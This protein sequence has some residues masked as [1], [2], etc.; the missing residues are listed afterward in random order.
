MVKQSSI[1][2]A[3]TLD[4]VSQLTGL[5][6]RQLAY[7]D[8]IGFY[9]PSLAQENRRVANSRV[10]TF[11]DLLA[12]QVLNTLRKDHRVSLQHLRAVKDRLCMLSDDEWK[13]RRLFVLNKKVVFDDAEGARREIVSGQYV[14]DIPLGVVRKN[15]ED[16]VEQIGR[17]TQAQIA[18]S[19]HRRGVT[20]NREVFAGTRIPVDAVRTFIE[21][22]FSDDDIL[23]QYP[24]LTSADVEM[25]RKTADHAA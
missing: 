21:D 5:S 19:E 1:I 3:F 17:R 8:R 16:A 12:L 6:K 4:A 20:H 13:E 14:L 15:M 9:S 7:W 24:T 18:Q 10:Y 22:G 25:A 23:R 11:N 2:R